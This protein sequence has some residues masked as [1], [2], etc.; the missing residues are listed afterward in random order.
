MF[1]FSLVSMILKNVSCHQIGIYH[2][3]FWRIMW[4]WSNDAENL[5]LTSQE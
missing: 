2:N 1:E 4:H 5:A 3:D